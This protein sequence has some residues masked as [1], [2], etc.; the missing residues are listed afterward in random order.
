MFIATIQSDDRSQ[1]HRGGMDCPK[2]PHAA[3]M[4]L[5]NILVDIA[6][7]KH[8]TPTGLGFPDVRVAD[9]GRWQRIL[10]PIKLAHPKPQRGAAVRHYQVPRAN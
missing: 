10:R 9:S 6:G 5:D 1:P 8:G 4:G 2:H 7:Y 3:P